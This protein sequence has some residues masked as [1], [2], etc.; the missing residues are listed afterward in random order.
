MTQ[1]RNTIPI[2]GTGQQQTLDKDHE[3]NQS[4][5]GGLF[6]VLLQGA[7]SNIKV[8]KEKTKGHPSVTG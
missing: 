6:H 3:V 7:R 8:D 2:D 5:L 1:S 4:F